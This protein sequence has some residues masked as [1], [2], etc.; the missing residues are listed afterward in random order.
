MWGRPEVER[1]STRKFGRGR[2]EMDF[3]D[4]VLVRVR[5]RRHPLGGLTAQHDRLASQVMPLGNPAPLSRPLSSWI[6]LH[7]ERSSP[8][9]P[10]TLPRLELATHHPSVCPSKARGRTWLRTNRLQNKQIDHLRSPRGDEVQPRRVRATDIYPPK[11][12]NRS[13]RAIR[14][15]VS[16]LT[17]AHPPRSPLQV[18]R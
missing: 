15:R 13:L 4:D 6:L 11:Q 14:V 16:P 3:C 8:S 17:V 10:K 7:P 9:G 5:L 1:C 2:R 12:V 18:E